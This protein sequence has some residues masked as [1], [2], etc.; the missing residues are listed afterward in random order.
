MRGSKIGSLLLRLMSVVLLLGLGGCEYETV[1]NNYYGDLSDGGVADK[2]E[3]EMSGSLFFPDDKLQGSADLAIQA[4]PVIGQPGKA[5]LWPGPSNVGSAVLIDL[6]TKD[7]QPH[8]ISVVLGS[9]YVLPSGEGGENAEI[10][11]SLDIGVGGQAYTAEVDFVSGTMFSLVASSLRV[12]GYY[13]Y[14]PGATPQI[15]VPTQGVAA[16]VAS[17]TVIG[18]TPQRTL[19]DTTTI[20]PGVAHYFRVPRF[21]KSM[22][23]L[24]SPNNAEL[25]IRLYAGTDYVTLPVVGFPSAVIPLPSFTQLVYFRNTS[26]N[27]VNVVSLVFDLAL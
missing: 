16:S 19:T 18:G 17:G 6:R 21:A 10:V 7:H 25:E 15:N 24:G 20:I 2:S 1:T 23:V 4:P 14:L 8:V 13:R 12:S 9:R 5:T 22:R 11:A 26:L 3:D 27:N